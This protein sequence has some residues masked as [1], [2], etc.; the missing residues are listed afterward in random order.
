MHEFSSF[1]QADALTVKYRQIL[2]RILAAKIKMGKIIKDSSFAMVQ[3]KYVAGDGV[4]H[5]IFDAVETAAIKVT[6]SRRHI[7]HSLSLSRTSFVFRVFSQVSRANFAADRCL[8]EPFSLLQ[9]LCLNLV[10]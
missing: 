1:S 3:A 10:S 7:L 6:D 4:K 9:L 2:K 5:T 8:G